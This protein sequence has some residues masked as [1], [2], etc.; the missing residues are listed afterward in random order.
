[1]QLTILKKQGTFW[2]RGESSSKFKT[3][4][5]PT[6]YRV[7]SD[8]FQ[9]KIDDL[10]SS[11]NIRDIERNINTDFYR[12][13]FPYISSLGI[14]NS[15]WN[16]YFLMQHYN[17]STRLLDWT[18]NEL[19][20]LFFAINDKGTMSDDA[21][22]WILEPFNLNNHTIK[23]ILNTDK[24]CFRIPTCNDSTTPKKLIS[25]TDGL[26]FDELTRRYLKMD[27][28]EENDIQTT[29]Y[30]LAIYPTHLDKRMSAQKACFTIFGNK[31]NG[32]NSIKDNKESILNSIIISGDKSKVEIL[33][34]LRLLGIDFSSIYPDL[35]GLGISINMKYERNL[36][37]N[38]ETLFH[39]LNES[40]ALK[41]SR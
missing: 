32:I 23:T 22:V 5:V 6:S 3:P 9:N 16:R 10:F 19:L 40:G 7:L 41:P 26:N 34:E 37:D 33:K 31:I 13:A 8:T 38:R 15:E 18:E 11:T 35:D 1:M 36:K 25:T 21:R 17:I 24:T 27:F 2:F 39:I 14:D 12:K 30:P 20:A 29:Y 4:L 28:I